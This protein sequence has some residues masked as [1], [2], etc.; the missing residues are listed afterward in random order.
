[1]RKFRQVIFR[2]IA[3]V[4][5]IAGGIL[6]VRFAQAFLA[7]DAPAEQPVTRIKLT[8]L[9][10][11]PS[12]EISGMDWYGDYLVMLPQYPDQLAESGDGF[13]FALPK[14]DILA[15][16]DGQNTQPLEPI[17]VPLE[18]PGLREKI[19]EYE[20]FESIGFLGDRAYLT[21][22]AGEDEHMMGYL[23]SGLMAPDLSK[24][25]IDTD[26]LTLIPS[27]TEMDNKADEAIIV[28]EDR[29]IT[30]YE[31]NGAAINPQPVAHVF[32]LDL[33]PQATLP[34]PALEYRLT[35][36]TSVSHGNRF[37]VVNIFFFYKDGNLKPASDPLTETFGKGPTHAFFYAVERLVEMEYSESGVTL[38]DTPPVQLSL[39][40]LLTRNWEGL[41][42]LDERG[43][44]LMTDKF[45]VTMLAFVPM[46]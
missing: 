15:Y 11:D 29:I 22:E 40:S 18:A 16:L 7:P 33:Q 27:Q 25:T 5:L 35:D 31:A 39:P 34:A 41:V 46:P 36:A 14:A 24:L 37:W 43:F 12:A 10:A 38:T 6:V 26:R 3:A 23:V 42:L 45:P 44:L 28:L 8:G 9:L 32:S 30:L 2:V 19:L 17:V 21:I 4:C 13:V 1:M 20:G